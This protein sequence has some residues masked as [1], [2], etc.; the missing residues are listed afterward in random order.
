MR[1]IWEKSGQ[2]KEAVNVSVS[3][4]SLTSAII[5][6]ILAGTKYSGDGDINGKELRY[7]LEELKAI[8]QAPNIGD[9]LPYLDW[10]D[11]QGINRR[12]KKAHLFFDR[13][14]QKIIDDHV[15]V[16]RKQTS[17]VTDIIDVLL[18]RMDM[19]IAGIDTTA[20]SLEW[21]MSLLVRNPQIADKLQEEI[22]SVV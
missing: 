15:N 3:I 13:V 21:T 11:L 22:E 14:V 19:F 5:W 8:I 10:L 12:M 6:R 17:N 18:E 16:K 9:F 20:A 4:Q 2:G 1:G 7:M